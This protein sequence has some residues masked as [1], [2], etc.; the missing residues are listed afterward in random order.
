MIITVALV[1]TIGCSIQLNIAQ[2]G[3]IDTCD[4]YVEG[5][6]IDTLTEEECDIASTVMS[7]LSLWMDDSNYR[8]LEHEVFLYENAF[9]KATY[10]EG[11]YWYNPDPNLLEIAPEGIT[12]FVQAVNSTIH[13]YESYESTYY[14]FYLG[15]E[16]AGTYRND[17]YVSR[18]TKSESIAEY[19]K[20]FL[21][22][23]RPDPD[24]MHEFGFFFSPRELP[25]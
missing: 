10:M 12:C 17:Y 1:F 11:Y 8:E 20:H 2:G 22:E 9:V 5:S 13:E 14:I 21:P 3:S 16:A 19:F 25:A 6:I 23:Y 15:R 24:F 18:R 4:Y 7:I